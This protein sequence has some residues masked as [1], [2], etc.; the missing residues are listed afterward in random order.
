MPLIRRGASVPQ[1]ISARV[2]SRRP[3]ADQSRRSQP[4][5]S[6][7]VTSWRIPPATSARSMMTSPS[8]RAVSC[9][10]A[11]PSAGAMHT[12]V[13]S[14]NSAPCPRVARDLLFRKLPAAHPGEP[15]CVE[16]A[17]GGRR[18][19]PRAASIL[20]GGRQRQSGYDQDD[21][22]NL[23]HASH[24]PVL[25]EPRSYHY[26]SEHESNASGNPEPGEVEIEP[27]Q[28]GRRDP[29]PPMRSAPPWSGGHFASGGSRSRRAHGRSA[30]I[31]SRRS[32][33][34]R[35]CSRVRRRS[36]PASARR[37]GRSGRRRRRRE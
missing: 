17:R 14:G 30:P 10:P 23:L 18:R 31:P 27:G 16:I 28:R 7:S 33:R 13:R 1:R 22:Q 25:H 24:R 11:P 35:C 15:A 26:A 3:S 19:L 4:P 34:R 9:A 36:L 37:S 29:P 21:V 20:R 6:P 12:T 32:R 2:K 8:P 5:Q